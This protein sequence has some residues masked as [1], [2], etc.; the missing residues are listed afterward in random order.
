MNYL[1]YKSIWEWVL[2]LFLLILFSPVIIVLASSLSFINRG[3]PFFIAP[4]PGKSGKLFSPIKFK[5]MTDKR[6]TLG[7]MLPD[8]DRI[9]IIGSL[10]RSFSLDELPQL[11]N[12][13]KGEM[14]LIGPR[15]LLV[16]YLPLYT[17]RQMR[18]HDVK[19][20]ITGWAQVN[21]RNALSWREKFEHDIWYVEHMNCILDMR[22]L[23]LTIKKVIIRE[24]INSAPGE[25]MKKFTGNN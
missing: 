11:I 15:P 16:D 4:R 25:P 14:A 13:I 10:I 1:F 20:G 22:I 12:V 23:F 17:S 7:L 5:T 6:D 8:E 9:T 3:S 18:R 24:S 21:G 2:A 19:P